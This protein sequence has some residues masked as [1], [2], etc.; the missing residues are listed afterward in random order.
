MFDVYC[1]G[2][3]DFLVISN[4][5]PMPQPYSSK[6][7]RRSRSRVHKVSD[8]IKKAVQRQGYYLRSFGRLRRL[9]RIR[10]ADLLL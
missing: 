5:S 9:R 6:K 7:W 4:G 8:E 2:K 3:R 10:I 1:N